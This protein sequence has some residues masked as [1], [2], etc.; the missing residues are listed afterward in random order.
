[1]AVLVIALAPASVTH[2]QAQR[3]SLVPANTPRW[4]ASGSVGWLGRTRIESSA[5]LP[6][7]PRVHAGSFGASVSYHWTSHLTLEADAATSSNAHFYTY[8]PVTLSGR[9]VYRSYDHALRMTTT[10]GSLVYQ[11]LANQWV[12][13][14][15][16]VGV[17]GVRERDR[18]ESLVLPAFGTDGRADIP[19]TSNET[20]TTFAV[21]P[22]VG[23]GFKFYV[24]EKAFI[25]TDVR[26]SVERTP[27]ALWR[28]GI[29]FDF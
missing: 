1:M 22:I 17:E 21:R 7:E 27:T 18:I 14:F 23:G 11:P 3:I 24:A 8:E 10:S 9:A 20:K 6:D 28:A 5:A 26:F 13:P 2:A 29:G 16:A 4:E 12:Q 19:A 25:R 15:V